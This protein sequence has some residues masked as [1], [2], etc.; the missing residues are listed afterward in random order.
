ML[1]TKLKKSSESKR[2][3]VLADTAL[4]GRLFDLI[5]RFC[6]LYKKLWY[7]AASLYIS[8]S[9]EKLLSHTQSSLSFHFYR[10]LAAKNRIQEIKTFLAKTPAG[11]I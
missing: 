9:N 7:L 10:S 1:L 6:V 5:N 11:K 8:L 3:W 4:L 2:N